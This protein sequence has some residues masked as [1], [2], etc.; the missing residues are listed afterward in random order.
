M[1]DIQKEIQENLDAIEE[2]YMRTL[3]KS[4]TKSPKASK[5]S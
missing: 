3:Q 2:R 5:T 4:Y 1:R